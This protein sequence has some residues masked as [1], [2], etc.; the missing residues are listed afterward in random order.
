MC[1]LTNMRNCIKTL[2]KSESPVAIRASAIAYL[3]RTVDENY[4]MADEQNDYVMEMDAVSDIH[5]GM[6]HHWLAVVIVSQR[7][8]QSGGRRAQIAADNGGH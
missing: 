2:I 3:A 1:W 4:V 5:I 8:D 6:F 7:Q